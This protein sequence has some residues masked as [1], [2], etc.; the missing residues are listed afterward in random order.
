LTG[1][2]DRLDVG[3]DPRFGELRLDDFSFLDTEGCVDDRERKAKAIGLT[4][5]SQEG[6]GL[7]EIAFNGF[8]RV[9]LG[10]TGG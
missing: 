3:G 1:A 9:V 7:V 4:A 6:L 8:D 2:V 5:L 10:P